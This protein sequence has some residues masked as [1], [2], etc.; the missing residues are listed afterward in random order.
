MFTLT[1]Y[2]TEAYKPKKPYSFVQFSVKT[3]LFTSLNNGVLTLSIINTTFLYGLL[4]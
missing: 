4:K 1:N 2:F 3:D